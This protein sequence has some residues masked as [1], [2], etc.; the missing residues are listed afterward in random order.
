M[1]LLAT[2]VGN[3]SIHGA[4]I[5]LRA[6]QLGFLPKD[7]KTAIAFS[8]SPLPKVFIVVVAGTKR[9][10]LTDKT[11]PLGGSSWGQLENCVELDF[12]R[13]EIQGSTSC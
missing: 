8:K 12:S 4:E 1:F 6:S 5:F 10:C 13:L 7:T 3:V 9:V 11:L 2:W